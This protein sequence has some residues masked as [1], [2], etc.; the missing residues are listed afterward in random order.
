[1]T[2]KLNN[3]KVYSNFAA[4]GKRFSLLAYRGIMN[5]CWVAGDWMRNSRPY[6]EAVIDAG[7]GL[8]SLRHKLPFAE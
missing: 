3:H 2:W 5:S 8:L 6:L 1:M 4:T 7:V